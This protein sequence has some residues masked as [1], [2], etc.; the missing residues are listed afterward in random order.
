M[1]TVFTHVPL[2][3]ELLLQT[4]DFLGTRVPVE[5]CVPLANPHIPPRA[6]SF[7]SLQQDTIML[8]GNS[9]SDNMGGHHIVTC[10]GSKG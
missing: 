1:K 10:L 5:G 8:V 4:P 9:G 6:R 3:I 7:W 2:L